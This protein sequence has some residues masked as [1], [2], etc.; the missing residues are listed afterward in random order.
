MILFLFLLLLLALLARRR[1]ELLVLVIF[2][3]EPAPTGLVAP[4]A[5]PVAL[6][7]EP[8]GVRPAGRLLLSFSFAFP[9]R[10]VSLSRVLSFFFPCP[11][12]LNDLFASFLDGFG[13]CWKSKSINIA[14][15]MLQCGGQGGSWEGLGSLQGPS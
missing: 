15:K 12:M 7:L 2:L 14:S 5:A 6:T 13:L 9:F 10:F 8:L 3:L 1:P 11:A 4:A